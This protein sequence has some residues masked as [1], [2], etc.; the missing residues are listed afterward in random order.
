MVP[1]ILIS[2]TGKNK[3][4]MAQ[5]KLLLTEKIFFKCNI[6][7]KLICISNEYCLVAKLGCRITHASKSRQN[8]LMHFR[9]PTCLVLALET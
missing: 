8:S 9:K 3:T 4:G 1:E 7:S 2:T 5:Y 6:K